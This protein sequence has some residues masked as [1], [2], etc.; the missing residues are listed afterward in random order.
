M[1]AASRVTAVVVGA[2][3]N[4]L[5]MSKRLS[6]RGVDHVVLERSEVANSWRTQRWDSF[7]MLTPN[8]QARLPGLRVRRRRSGRLHDRRRDRRASSRRYADTIDGTGRGRDDGDH[9]AADRRRL[10]GR[11]RSGHVAVPVRRV[12]RGCVQPPE[13]PGSRG[14][15]SRRGRPGQPARLPASRSTRRR[16]RPRGRRR[17][18]RSPARRGDPCLGSAGDAVGRRARSDA[19]GRTAAPTSSTGW[20]PSDV[21]TSATTR[22]RRSSKARK[23]ASPQLVGTPERRTLDLNSVTDSGVQL[24]GRLGA[25]RDGVAMFSGGLRNHCA[26][27]DQKLGRLLDDIDAW[28]DEHGL[29]AEVGPAERYEPTRV[30]RGAPLT[31]DLNSGEITTIVWATGFRPDLSWVDLP[32]FDP[33]GHLRH[34]GGVVDAPGVYFLGASFLRRRRSSFLH[35]AVDDTQGSGRPPRRPPRDGSVIS[36]SSRCSRTAGPDRATRGPRARAQRR[37]RSPG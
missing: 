27:A 3:H 15:S 34:D 21:S 7:T 4:G 32:V 13:H 19:D 23:V 25:I 1:S 6:D 31:L 8:W 24:R 30:A 2:G 9:G 22:S 26:L 35:G 37:A 18:N 17:G 29:D 16:W 11:H 12:G 36:A 10:R 20:R 14:G 5:A 33:A 28:I